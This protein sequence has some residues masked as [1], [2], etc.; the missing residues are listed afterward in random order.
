MFDHRILLIIS[1]LAAFLALSASPVRFQP[2]TA[3]AASGLVP[4]EVEPDGVVSG[5][6]GES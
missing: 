5:E 3:T 2:P 1:L 6:R 4:I